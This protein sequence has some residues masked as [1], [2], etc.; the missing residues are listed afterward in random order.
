MSQEEEHGQIEVIPWIHDIPWLGTQHFR[1]FMTRTDHLKHSLA[2]HIEVIA[3]TIQPGLMGAGCKDS[4]KELC[5]IFPFDQT[6]DFGFESR[7]GETAAA[8]DFSFLIMKDS[9]GA[10]ILSGEN[11]ISDLHESTLADPFWQRIRNFF[12]AWNSQGHLLAGSVDSV[13]LEFDYDGISYNR[14]PNIFFGIIADSKTGQKAQGQSRIRVLDEIYHILFDIPFPDELSE[15]LRMA[16]NALPEHASLYQTG[17]MIPRQTEAVRLVLTQI[18]ADRL[19]PYLRDIG[20]PGDFQI[21]RLLTDRYAGLFDYFACNINI[22][23]EILPYLALEMIFNNLSQPGFNPRWVT[24]LD[25]LESDKLVSPEKR[26]AL[27]RFCGITKCGFPHH[28][29]YLRGINHLKIVYKKNKPFE[30]KGYFGT[31]M[32]E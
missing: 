2:D 19:E 27:L 20:W 17:F 11:Q 14:C 25:L 3:R 5:S 4:L 32:R 9:D 16:I 22:G 7:L 31:M 28:A 13:W 21:A 8:C 10:K 24:A 26:E 30:C 1:H 6:R 29:N 18:N 15:N 12:I 23:K